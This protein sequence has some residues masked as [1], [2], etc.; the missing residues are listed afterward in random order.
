MSFKKLVFKLL[1]V[2]TFVSLRKFYR[3]VLKTIYKPLSAE[4]FKYILLNRLGIHKG[5]VA[6][7]HSSV[8]ALNIDFPIYNL[9]DMLL[10]AVGENGT[11][12]FPAWHFTYRAE[13]YLKKGLIFDV[14]RSP[15]FLG[16]LSE[17]ARDILMP[18]GAF[19][20]LI[21]LLQ[22][23]NMPGRS[24]AN[25]VI[26]FIPAMKPALIIRSWNLMEL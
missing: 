2:E 22:L 14:R 4:E 23:A 11:L 9:L 12:V 20:L 13:E 19:I 21:Q 8:D 18:K 15:S 5:S 7:I 3:K 6:F 1:P 10:D 25:M 17:F 26:P 24:L 16:A